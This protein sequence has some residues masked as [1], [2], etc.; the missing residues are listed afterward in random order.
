MNLHGL[1]RRERYVLCVDNVRYFTEN[2][3]IE[4]HGLLQGLITFL[5]LNVR[6]SHETHVWTF[7]ACYGDSFT[8]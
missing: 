7:A 2:T 1:L 6:T 4:L 8:F 5:Y 3:H